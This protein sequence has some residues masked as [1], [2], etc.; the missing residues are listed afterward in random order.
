M[1]RLKRIA[2]IFPLL[3]A[4][5]PDYQRIETLVDDLIRDKF[6]ITEKCHLL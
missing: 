5:L 2:R 3:K 1:T 6:S 4:L